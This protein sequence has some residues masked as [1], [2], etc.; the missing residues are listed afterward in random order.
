MITEVC[1]GWCMA[2]TTID[3]IDHQMMM[4][5]MMT[6]DFFPQPPSPSP[7]T[8]KVAKMIA[9]YILRA[10]EGWKFKLNQKT[11]TLCWAKEKNFFFYPKKIKK[12]LN[13]DFWLVNDKM[14]KNS[15]FGRIKENWIE[16]NFFFAE[17][18]SNKRH[19]WL[20]FWLFF[21]HNDCI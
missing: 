2:D 16:L 8:N 6:K 18:T 12:F 3:R 20:C 4:M 17:K 21:I 15:W 11:T 9:N 1:N 13:R 7:R 14:G 10:S 19:T 5:M